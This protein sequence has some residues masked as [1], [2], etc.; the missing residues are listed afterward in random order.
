MAKRRTR[1]KSQQ[2]AATR[3]RVTLNCPTPLAHRTLDIEAD[4]EQEAWGLFMVAN[5]I[6]DSRH[7]RTIEKINGQPSNNQDADT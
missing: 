5:G 2:S 1:R 7:E 3:Y 6:R 4:N